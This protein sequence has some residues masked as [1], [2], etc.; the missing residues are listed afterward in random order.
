MFLALLKWILLLASV[1]NDH[2][3]ESVPSI[4]ASRGIFV[5][6]STLFEIPLD[7]KYTKSEASH[8]PSLF[9]NAF[10]EVIVTS[11]KK[12]IGIENLRASISK[13]FV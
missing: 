2:I 7:D 13:I 11:T 8:F 6:S 5:A 4:V 10:P 9:A 12:N 3:S 1:N